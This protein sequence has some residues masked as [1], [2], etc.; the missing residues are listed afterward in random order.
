MGRSRVLVVGGGIGGL[1]AAIALG[2]AQFDVTVVER[3]ADVHSSV[4][5]VGIIQ[6]SNALRALEAI[7]CAHA[8]IAAGFPA[9][10]WGKM[11]D[12]DGNY[13]HDIPGA[14]IEG[15][16]LPPM[17]GLTRPKLHEILTDRALEVG[18]VIRYSTTFASLEQDPDGVTATLTDGSTER[19]DF[20]VGADGVRSKVRGYVLDADIQ[21]SY[22]GQSAFRVNIPRDPEI[23]R[24]IIQPSPNGVAGF[25]PIG[26]DLAYL[27]FNSHMERPPRDDGSNRAA[28][29]REHLAPFG[30]LTAR[31][32]DTCI[33]DSAD[34]VLRPEESLIAPAPWHRGR[35]V[36]LGDAVHAITPHLGQGA[37]QA[38]EDAVV[39][40]EVLT[41]H[42]TLEAAF[43]AYTERRFE[44]CK[45]IVE[46]SVAIGEWEMGRR[47]DF[48]N[49]ATT[50][51][52]LKVMA[53]PI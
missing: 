37:A 5:G 47:P 1:S 28:A 23:D 22:I 32:R 26:Q 17:N 31:V 34:V 46:T 10:G 20:V 11:Y 9:S 14:V 40:A 45:L 53:E 8:C 50:D 24:I 33:D 51:H 25:V 41:E 52:V 39:L 30:G 42:D 21:P 15:Y 13:I 27:F 2:M 12:V 29:L 3:Q 4:Y 48:D 38:I 16:D 36:L 49:V 44:R 7:G 18:A 43:A 6:P 19:F 35:I